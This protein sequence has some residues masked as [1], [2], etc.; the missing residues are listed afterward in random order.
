MVKSLRYTKSLITNT[1]SLRFG[2]WFLSVA[3]TK[4]PTIKNF[5]KLQYMSNVDEKK[6]GDILKTFK[7]MK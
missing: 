5:G 2:F 6:H 4:Q 3:Q 7:N 1:T